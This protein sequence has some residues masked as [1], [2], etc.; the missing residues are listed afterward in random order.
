MAAIGLRA[1]GAGTLVAAFDAM[2][3]GIQNPKGP[4]L[5]LYQDVITVL[6]AQRF[7][8][9]GPGW[10]PLSPVYAARKQQLVGRKP[11]LQFSGALL[12]ALTGHRGA[13]YTVAG[14]TLTIHPDET[15]PY[16]KAHQFGTKYMPARP[17]LS[18]STAQQ[19]QMGAYLE[20]QFVRLAQ[21]ADIE[22][23]P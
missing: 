4:L 16:W 21:R 19:Q 20:Q 17:P 23:R 7:A 10:A 6:V 8:A 11:I 3:T 5:G 12:S 14:N 13:V 9:E 2:A 1:E 15:V 22:V 18:F